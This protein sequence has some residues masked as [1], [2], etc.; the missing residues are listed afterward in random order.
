MPVDSEGAQLKDQR[1]THIE[2]RCV[3]SLVNK[4]FQRSSE[5]PY[6]KFEGL[7]I[8]IMHHMQCRDAVTR[9]DNLWEGL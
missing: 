3:E 5:F 1:I 6:L 2:R 4:G 8:P 7:V 9:F